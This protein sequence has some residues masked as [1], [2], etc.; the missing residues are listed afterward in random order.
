MDRRT[1]LAT[2]SGAFTA[3]VTSHAMA[4]SWGI[5]TVAFQMS[6]AQKA[7]HVIQFPE[8]DVN[9]NMDFVGGFKRWQKEYGGSEFRDGRIAFLKANGFDPAAPTDVG[10]EQCHKILMQDSKYAAYVRLSRTIQEMMW[11][12]ARAALYEREDMYMSAMEATDKTGPGTLE[13]NP[14]VKFPEYTAYEIHQQP[15]GYVGDQFSGM[16]YHYALALAFYQGLFNGV[17]R[18]DEPHELI[19]AR[20][21]LPADGKVKRIV[22]LGCSDG[23]TV[24]ALK[25]RFPDA[26]VW[27]LD[28]GGPMVRYGHS[29]AA[30]MGLDVNFAQRLAED[31]HFPDHH[32]DIVLT[33][34]IFHEVPAFAATKIVQEAN[35]ILRP[36]G[37]WDLTDGGAGHPKLSRRPNMVTKAATWVNHRYNNETWEIQWNGVDMYKLV[38]GTGFKIDVDFPKWAP[39]KA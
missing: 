36:G 21:P 8:L 32:F 29:R 6:D 2:A 31:T 39:V 38:T 34:L 18:H 10:F 9:S 7:K 1:L 5:D 20:T 25:E 16:L 24:I 22:E 4:D 30:R 37:V 15:G 28:V 33:N 11:S 23:R 3:A 26:E 13:L 19:V 35:R 14:S 17:V 27:G 12:R